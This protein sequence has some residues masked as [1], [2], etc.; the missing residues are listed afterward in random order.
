MGKGHQLVSFH[1]ILGNPF[2]IKICFSQKIICPDI[3]AW[4]V[5]LKALHRIDFVFL[6]TD[7]LIITASH[8]GPGA[9]I[10]SLCRL[11]KPVK[12]LLL[13]SGLLQFLR[14]DGLMNGMTVLCADFP[15]I[16]CLLR[17]GCNDVLV[18][19]G[20]IAVQIVGC[21]IDA[22]PK[23]FPEPV[24]TFGNVLLQIGL[25][26]NLVRE[27][28]PVLILDSQKIPPEIG[29]SHHILAESVS[30]FGQLQCLLESFL[31]TGKRHFILHFRRQ[32]SCTQSH[33]HSQCASLLHRFVQQGNGT[34][35]IL[36]KSMSLPHILIAAQTSGQ[37]A[38]G[39]SVA[40]GGS[41][42][43]KGK[44]LPSSSR[45]LIVVNVLQ[46]LF[47]FTA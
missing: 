5:F 14:I 3:T 7:S 46:R 8:I 35:V 31:Q 13:P 17:S 29:I 45:P 26:G 11:L 1:V 41:S 33:Q 30:R 10:A 23:G 22:S 19:L 34:V 36:R 2:P 4:N 25:E 12:C 16:L 39:V 47:Y 20:I 9:R 42:L 37:H 24:L 28:I 15:E 21:K 38:A 27:R 32:L 6:H 43:Q 44:C 18:S 40:L